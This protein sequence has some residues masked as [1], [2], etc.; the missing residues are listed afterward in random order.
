MG[1]NR[2]GHR[3]FIGFLTGHGNF[4]YRLL[5]WNLPEKSLKIAETTPFW[6]RLEAK[7]YFKP[8]RSYSKTAI[9]IL[10]QR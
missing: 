2:M 8:A 4:F 9:A 7:T 10:A 1:V 6:R 3:S 5:G